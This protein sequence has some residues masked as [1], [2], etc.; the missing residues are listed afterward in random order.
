MDKEM[1]TEQHEENPAPNT[2]VVTEEPERME[3]SEGEQEAEEEQETAP[4]ATPDEAAQEEQEVA[5]DAAP[6]EAAEEE[7]EVAPDAAPDEAAEEEQE[8]APDVA[9]DE[10]AEEEQ[11]V[12][13]PEAKEAKDRDQ[14]TFEEYLAE[15]QD[16]HVLRRGD[17]HQG[18]VV[19][20]ND[21]GVI[22]DFGSKREGFV[23]AQ[24]LKRLADEERE[25]VKEGETVPV[26]VTRP[27]GRQG[28]P[29]LSINQAYLHEDW[30][31]ADQMKEEGKIYEGEVSGYNR[32]GLI[33]RFG[34][35]RG[36]VPASQIVG[37]PRRLSEEKRRDR[38]SNLIGETMGLKIIEVDRR[39]R[40]L[41]FSQRRAYR[42][43]QEKQRE[44]VISE[45]KEGE[46]R[47]GRV[48]DITNFGAFV[49]LGGADGLI[50]ISELSWKRVKTPREVVNVGDE[51]DV[52]VIS[53]D[54]KRKRIGL[55]LKK[56]QPNPWEEVADH[57]DEGE[58]IE[59][60][61]TRVMDF[62]AFIEV[63]L[64]IEGLLPA[65]EM[66]GTPEL[67]PKQLLNAG[68]TLPVKVIHIDSGRRRLTLSARRV[69]RDEWERWM[70]RQ[71]ELEAEEEAAAAAEEAEDAEAEPAPESAVAEAEANGEEE[72]TEQDA[73][74]A[75]EETLPEAPADENEEREDEEADQA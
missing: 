36:F 67:K 49:D 42:Q 23:P 73:A 30:I 20:I 61:I 24:D 59:G 47:H 55:S 64:G 34:K 12:A 13:P 38:L 66:I 19:Q 44:R 53:L 71:Q 1:E 7:Q 6:D 41:I 9:P 3:D 35:I 10:A 45:L 11:E 50:H 40:R 26:V 25:Q 69:R 17:L 68:E 18:V 43:W 48:T 5:P 52:Y 37:M 62:G 70:A 60:K 31:K 29:I 8:V 39:R 15:S 2:P 4:E 51:V 58:I 74:P 21:D 56:L 32:G 16:S 63:D 27:E 65:S 28:N 57:Y 14:E 72:T 54:R 33:V 75:E 46:I 22:I